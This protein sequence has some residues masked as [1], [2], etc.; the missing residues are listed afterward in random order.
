VNCDHEPGV[1][2]SGRGNSTRAGVYG[3]PWVRQYAVDS[4]TS[5]NPR[6]VGSALFVGM[7]CAALPNGRRLSAGGGRAVSKRTR[8]PPC[9]KERDHRRVAWQE[10]RP[11]LEI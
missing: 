5:A 7:T 6:C 1:D 10:Q 3:I 4:V 8:T 2:A 11:T 9:G